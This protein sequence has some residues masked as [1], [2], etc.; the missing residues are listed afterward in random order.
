MN[1]R[2]GLVGG[3]D[4]SQKF[5][6]STILTWVGQQT[7]VCPSHVHFSLSWLICPALTRAHA[8][9][10]NLCPPSLSSSILSCVSSLYCTALALRG[11]SRPRDEEDDIQPSVML[12]S[13]W[14]SVSTPLS[15][16]R[17]RIRRRF[18][19]STSVVCVL[20]DFFHLFSRFP[21]PYV[22]ASFFLFFFLWVHIHAKIPVI[23]PSPSQ[24]RPR[25]GKTRIK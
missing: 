8:A 2:V 24:R 19:F 25:S 1:V 3:I 23:L 15:S 18:S 6:E 21:F 5:Q 20:S 13:Q 17:T 22:C 16:Q 10:A 14:M 12:D 7:N 11:D 9:A 4:T